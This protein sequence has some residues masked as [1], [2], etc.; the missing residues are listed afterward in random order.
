VRARPIVDMHGGWTRRSGVEVEHPLQ[1]VQ[2][3]Y[4]LPGASVCEWYRAITQRGAVC[5]V[6]EEQPGRCF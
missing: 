1:L 6:D 2:C 3:V 4:R 5:N